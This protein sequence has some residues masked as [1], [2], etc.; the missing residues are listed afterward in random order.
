MAWIKEPSSLPEVE[1]L[2]HALYEPVPPAA[3]SQIQ[4]ILHRV[5]RST[6]AWSVARDLLA[7]P[8][9][10]VRFFGALTLIVKL[11]TDSSSLA[12]PELTELFSSLLGWFAKSALDS[13]SGLV[14][15]KLSTALVTFFLY[16]PTHSRPCLRHLICC[17]HLQRYANTDELHNALAWI[18]DLSPRALQAAILFAADLVE[19][20]AKVDLNS[21]NHL[22]VYD[23][24]RESTDDARA[25]IS[26]GLELRAESA[27]E[28]PLRR[29]AVKCL[30]PWASFAHRFFPRSDPLL[31]SL[32]D[33]I[34]LVVNGLTTADEAI[35]AASMELL[36]ELLSNHRGFLTASHSQLLLDMC[37]GPVGD[38][39]YNRLVQGDFE[40]EALQ[41]GLF[42]I[43]LADSQMDVLVL[44]EPDDSC[45]KLLD[46][47]CG[48]LAAKG[49]PAVEDRI[50]IPAI[51]F[52]STYA[53]SI[54]DL[55]PNIGKEQRI[56][57]K[58]LSY[59]TQAVQFA[60][61]RII[62]PSAEVIADWDSTERESFVDARKDVADFL[63]SMYT[64]SGRN[65]VVEFVELTVRAITSQLWAE[66]EA[67][68]FCLGAF[69][70][71]IASESSC[72][73]V[74]KLIF[75]STLFDVL[76]QEN[77]GIPSRT[78]QTCIALIERFAE[79][80]ER[81][82]SGL[83]N[84]L[85]L[86]FSALGDPV[87]TGSASKSI[88]KL[89]S[90][91]AAV[92]VPEVEIFL[93]EYQRITSHSQV[94]CL[95]N[96]RITG[97]IGCVIQACGN[98]AAR[99]A[100]VHQ[101][102]DILSNDLQRCVLGAGNPALV[103]AD[104][105]FRRCGRRCLANIPI[106]EVP[107]H[108]CLRIL[109]CLF[110]L[111]KGLQAPVDIPFDLDTDKVTM[112]PGLEALC[113]V[114]SRIMTIITELQNTFP[115]SGEVVESICSILK[116]GFSETSPGPFVFS[117]D[118]VAGYLTRQP[119]STPRIGVLVSTACSFVSSITPKTQG[120]DKVMYLTLSWVIRLIRELPSVDSDPELSQ[121]G[122]D[123][124]CRLFVK[125]PGAFL[126]LEPHEFL[127]S[128]F[129]FTLSVLDG[130]EPLPKATAAEF[131]VAGPALATF[132]S[133]RAAHSHQELIQ[134]VI[135]ELGPSLTL[136]LIRNI[137]G[138]ASRSELDKLSEPLKRLASHHTMAQTWIRAALFHPTFPS[139]NVSDEAKLSFM[140]KVISLRGRRETNHV[141]REF[142]LASRGSK[143]TYAA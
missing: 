90:S 68:A 40:F 131:W 37:I 141:V 29:S 2:I 35:F 65:L 113:S 48:L 19:E 97:A 119:L 111:G 115:F 138:N 88:H 28:L 1:N 125:D 44:N 132:V 117:P 50:F 109:R 70:D 85:N 45:R 12:E 81:N 66:L 106:S 4:D 58:P 82:V 34:P 120:W 108:I 63:Q 56:S 76:L 71:C 133:Y 77:R 33:L 64:I 98:E 38:R 6:Q 24:I 102:L 136:S 127:G 83:P 22:A 75:S 3:V 43:A 121:H 105:N 135:Q 61:Q 86:L 96:E 78:R 23:G 46:L 95:A 31:G 80:F 32:R 79:Y 9:E 107:L 21:A 122:I 20:A 129:S 130:Q 60:C 55:S 128:F 94:D 15:R 124:C 84:A 69:A 57:F 143:F 11:N 92:L 53:E 42:M 13:S 39:Y 25:L 123:F 93:A 99:V 134:Q 112:H 67:A 27:S 30:Q 118:M 36:S 101:L 18:P 126:L 14:T 103:D 137:G 59:A 91:C 62:F 142:W 41:F 51:E 116:T 47:L 49:T 17:L 139:E 73:D 100:M 52:W 8:D 74:L 114:H 110:N 5:Q 10:K 140:R 7:R 104:P 89:C 16:F 87:L 26:F 54:A 72:D